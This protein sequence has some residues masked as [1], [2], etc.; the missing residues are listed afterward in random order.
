MIN[1]CIRQT[2]SESKIYIVIS[3]H[4]NT[5]SKGDFVL[6]T[7]FKMFI[8]KDSDIQKINPTQILRFGM[9]NSINKVKNP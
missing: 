2:K 9:T 6:K 7:R 8:F 4:E 1:N 5:N 3:Q